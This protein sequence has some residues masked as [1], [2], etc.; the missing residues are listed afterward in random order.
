M[1]TIKISLVALLIIIGLSFILVPSASAAVKSVSTGHATTCVVT[2]NKVKCWGDNSSGQLG[3]NSVWSS[4]T[5]TDVYAKAA[6]TETVPA[7]RECTF[8]FFC[9]ELPERK[10]N[11]NATPLGGKTVSK[12]S[13]GKNHVCAIAAAKVYCWGD[14]EHG[15]LGNGES[16]WLRKEYKPVAVATS[17]NSPSSALNVKEVIDVVAGDGFSCALSSDGVIACWGI[18]ANGQLGIGSRDKKNYPVAVAAGSKEFKKLAALKGNVATMCAI[19]TEDKA[20]CWGQNSLGQAGGASAP[21]SENGRGE[22]SDRQNSGNRCGI[23]NRRA[24]DEAI[25]GLPAMSKDE[26][27]PT[28]VR[29]GLKFKDITV[30]TTGTIDPESKGQWNTTSP[31]SQKVTSHAYTVAKTV[32]SEKI[33]WWGGAGTES[34]EMDCT[35]NGS[36]YYGER[37]TSDATVRRVFTKSSTPLGP[38]YVSPESNQLRNQ[39]I[40][41]LAGN[42]NNGANFITQCVDFEEK[43]SWWSTVTVNICHG[44]PEGI[45]CAISSPDKSSVYCDNGAETCTNNSDGSAFHAAWLKARGEWREMCTPYG[46]QLVSSGG[47]SWLKPSMTLSTIDVG[48]SDYVCAVTNV[49]SVGCWGENGDGQLGLGDTKDRITPTAVGL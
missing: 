9:K 23:A 7:H 40:A 33:Y 43:G 22:G 28:E 35:S 36:T 29:T 4:K 39:P 25:R 20:M 42:A 19:T 41:L 49:G 44:F 8:I 46:P 48:F 3:N 47:S 15:Q 37:S 24:Y 12:V 6:W 26:L 45:S 38:L 13:V 1:S 16:G 30:F 5:P 14:N 10:I 31:I 11:H 21:S 18:N 27:R 34:I 2:D 17:S 32:G